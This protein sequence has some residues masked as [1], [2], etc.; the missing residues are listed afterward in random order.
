[1][2]T[3]SAIVAVV[4]DL[5]RTKAPSPPFQAVAHSPLPVIDVIVMG[6][7][8]I[9]V[10]NLNGWTAGQVRTYLSM[11][12]K[13]RARHAQASIGIPPPFFEHRV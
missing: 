7:G 8:A 2:L 12:E 5:E 3:A 1:M 13:S 4:T 9:A 6:D 10:S 11:L